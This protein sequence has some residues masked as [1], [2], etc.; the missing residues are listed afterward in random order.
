MRARRAVT[1]GFI[2]WRTRIV[3]AFIGKDS[4]G[5]GRA[6]WSRIGGGS[7]RSVGGAPSPFGVTERADEVA[8]R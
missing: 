6:G 3:T 8:H 1:P 2:S 7:D 4:F 5:P